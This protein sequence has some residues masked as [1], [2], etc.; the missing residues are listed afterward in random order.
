MTLDENDYLT[1]QLYTASKSPR[2]KSARIKSWVISTLAFAALAYL[3]YRSDNT[4]LATY[5]LIAAGISAL[6]FPF[7]SKRRYK[8]HYLRFIRDTYKNRIGEACS[9]S[10]TDDYITTKDKVGEARI[11]TSEIEEINEIA[12]YYFIKVK[13]GESLIISKSKSEDPEHIK[14]SIKSLAAD[15]NIKHSIELDWRWK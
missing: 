12:D 7:Y 8:R 5:F 4:F 11:N 1:Y 3:F 9:V 6:F 15:K 14:N 2:I 10:I 13:S